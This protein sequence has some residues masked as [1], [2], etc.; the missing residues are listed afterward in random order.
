MKIKLAV[1][2]FVV[3]FLVTVVGALFKIEHWAGG[4][5]LLLTAM[6]LGVAGTVLVVM[7]LLARPSAKPN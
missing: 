6:A 3:A 1:I 7:K 4:D 2:F 5:A